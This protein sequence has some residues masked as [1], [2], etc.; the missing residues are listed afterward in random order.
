M[1][2]VRNYSKSSLF[3]TYNLFK[4]YVCVCV[5][6][7]T[8]ECICICVYGGCPQSPEE[9]IICPRAG[10]TGSCEWPDMSVGDKPM[11]S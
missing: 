1:W 7:Y 8:C 5:S 2:R 10:D 11:V 3:I 9:V 4:S 6:A